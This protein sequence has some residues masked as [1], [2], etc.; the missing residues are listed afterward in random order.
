MSDDLQRLEEWAGALIAKLQPA[1]RRQLVRKIANDLR[2]EHARLIA[3]QVAPDG[4]PY[5]ARKNRK[6]LR[7]KSGRIKR[8][9]AAMFGKLR[10][11]TYLQIR[12]DADQAS[13]GFFGKVARIARVHHE[14]LPDKVAPRGPSY[15]YPA[16]TLLGFSAGDTAELHRSIL[17]H[18]TNDISLR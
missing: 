9:K 8:Q 14:G 7:S 5:P 12:A 13:V 16:R 10:T 11:N 6:E 3:Q 18:L 2:R 15:K 1:Q 17:E 4:T